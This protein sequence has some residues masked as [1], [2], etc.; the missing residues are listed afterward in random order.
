LQTLLRDADLVVLHADNMDVIPFLG[1]AGMRERPPIVLVNHSD[2][3]FWLGAEFVDLVVSTRRSGLRLCAERRGIAEERNILLPLCLEPV[4]RRL[5]REEAKRALGLPDNSLVILSV[6]RA[7]KFKTIGG[8]SFA[9]ALVSVLRADSRLRLVAVGPGGAVDWSNAAAAVHG[10]LLT[11][12]E[13]PDTEAFLEAADVYVDSFPFVSITSMFEAGLHGLPI[14][15]RYPFGPGCEVLG[16]DSPG[17]DPVIIR[18]RGVA[19]FQ[20]AVQRLVVDQDLRAETGSRTRAEIEAVNMG[21]GW[22]CALARVYQR[23]FDLPRHASVGTII[24]ESPSFGELDLVAPFVYGNTREGAT[25]GA[26]LALATEINFKALPPG[27]R[28]RTWASMAWKR[29]FRYRSAS[30]AWRYLVP[31]W[32]GCRARSFVDWRI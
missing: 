2:H 12:A 22:E 7:V 15:T 27:L 9:D 23:A 10:Q 6:A 17:L 19:E 4:K 21:E 3:V 26:R 20:H 5:C 13:R 11:F 25:P 1:L 31:E 8:E 24:D 14:V 18:T 32:L 28:L 30:A 29:D 16:A